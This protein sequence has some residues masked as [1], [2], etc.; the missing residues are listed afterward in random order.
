MEQ[1]YSFDNEIVELPSQLFS[2]SI[3]GKLSSNILRTI[4]DILEGKEV[5]LDTSVYILKLAAQFKSEELVKRLF[6]IIQSKIG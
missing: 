6:P 5:S 3:S 1:I 4:Q 2:I